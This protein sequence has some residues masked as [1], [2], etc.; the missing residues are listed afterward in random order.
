MGF[1]SAIAKH[2]NA[3]PKANSKRQKQ[4]AENPEK[5][6]LIGCR[7]CGTT[8]GTLIKATDSYYCKFCFIKLKK[9]KFKK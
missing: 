3:V 1:M 4:K 2:N 6:R 5:I 8:K 7:N 9:Q